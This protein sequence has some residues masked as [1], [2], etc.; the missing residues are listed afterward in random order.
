VSGKEI[1]RYLQRFGNDL[2]YR[3]SPPQLQQ[4]KPERQPQNLSLSVKKKK[5]GREE[6]K[7]DKSD[8]VLVRVS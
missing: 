5:G 6:R 3:L 8:L 1:E 2:T 7:K 4:E